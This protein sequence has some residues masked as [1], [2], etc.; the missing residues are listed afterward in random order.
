MPE[1][2]AAAADELIDPA[3]YAETDYAIDVEDVE[4]VATDE[5][6]VVVSALMRSSAGTGAAL[7][8]FTAQTVEFEL[9]RVEGRWLVAEVREVAAP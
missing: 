6:R 1:S 8:K 3:A 5:D 2:A 9:E 7:Q 4:I